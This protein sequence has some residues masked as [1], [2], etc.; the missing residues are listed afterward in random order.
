MKTMKHMVSFSGGRTSAYLCHLMIEKF[1]RE[2]VDFVFMDTGAEHPKTYEFIKKCNEYFGL[3]LT[4]LK[5]EVIPTLGEGN[6]FSVQSINSLKWDL[7]RFKKLVAKY[8]NPYNP[9]GAFCT[10]Q[11]K[12]QTYK[13]YV[14]TMEHEV[15]SWIGIRADEP[16]RYLGEELFFELRKHRYTNDEII[17]IFFDKDETFLTRKARKL[18]DERLSALSKKGWR[19]LA[20]ISDFDKL[21]VTDFWDGMS[22]DL[23][24]PEFS[25]NC[26]FCPK[27]SPSRIALAQRESPELFD[28]W[29]NLLKGANPKGRPFQVDAIYRGKLTF[30]G[31]AE[32]YKNHSDDEIKQSLRRAKR[33]DAGCGSESCEAFGQID[34]FEGDE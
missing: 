13:K 29:N 20:E 9:G 28:D 21:D 6:S 2:N 25:G 4:V 11:L 23:E 3:N 5:I 22:F 1:G 16:K 19:F 7:E 17:K 27:K 24:A 10:D 8:G 12:T 31:I 14:K 32:L 18:M 33:Q 34:L 30:D 26:V 15:V